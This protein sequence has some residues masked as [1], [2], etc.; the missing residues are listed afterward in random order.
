[1]I[2]ENL[3]QPSIQEAV[4]KYDNGYAR[5]AERGTLL[6]EP[7]L[8]QEGLESLGDNAYLCLA[9]GETTHIP[10]KS[11]DEVIH[12][13]NGKVFLTVNESKRVLMLEENL[14]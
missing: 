3:E 8:N 10:L 1:M 4:V 13:G 6:V 11:I 5:H 9:T 2:R 12:Y 7:I 14:K